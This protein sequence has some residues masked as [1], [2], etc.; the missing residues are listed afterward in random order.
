ME[1]GR[2]YMSNYSGKSERM[3]E[4]IGNRDTVNWLSFSKWLS[5]K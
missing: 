3:K 5:Y 2:K 1:L 4:I